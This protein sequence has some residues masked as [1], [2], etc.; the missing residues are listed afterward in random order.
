M[1]NVCI[2]LYLFQVNDARKY[3]FTK[4]GRREAR[5]VSR[6]IC[7]TALKPPLPEPT[8]WGWTLGRESQLQPQWVTLPAAGVSCKEWNHCRCKKSCSK[9]C[10][11]V[12]ADPPCTPLCICDGQ[13][14][15]D[16]FVLVLIF[17]VTKRTKS[18]RYC[19]FVPILC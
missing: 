17:K 10:K 9:R 18:R 8:N 6:R 7:A 4:K 19:C 12:K 16:Q 13:C 2:Y 11:C 5:C 1:C 14:I 3:L 15:R